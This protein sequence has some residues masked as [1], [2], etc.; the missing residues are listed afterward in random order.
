MLEKKFNYGR[1]KPKHVKTFGVKK[2]FKN[3][4]S[5]SGKMKKTASTRNPLVLSK[6]YEYVRD[7]AN[8]S[9]CDA[10]HWIPKSKL[11]QDIFLTMI[12]YQEHQSIHAV[13]NS[14]NPAQWALEKGYNVLVEESMTYFY[15]WCVENNMPSEYFELIE[16]LKSDPLMAHDIARDFIFNNR[17]L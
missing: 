5:R 1:L 14:L 10:H 3:G 6:F 17:G 2:P 4:S 12:P 13:G 11:K 15:E 9:G 16:E 8:M 7:I